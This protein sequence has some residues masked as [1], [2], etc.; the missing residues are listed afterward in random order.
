MTIEFTSNMYVASLLL[1]QGA[2]NADENVKKYGLLKSYDFIMCEDD[3]NQ[4]EYALL[5]ERK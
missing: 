3:L 5:Q 1:K 4:P 2:S